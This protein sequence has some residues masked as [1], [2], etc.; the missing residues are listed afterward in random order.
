MIH[1]LCVVFM[2]AANQIESRF[3]Y[4][5]KMYNVISEYYTCK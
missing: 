3:V 5:W 2:Y 4:C 1:L